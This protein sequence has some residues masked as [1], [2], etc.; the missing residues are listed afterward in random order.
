MES[1]SNYQTTARTESY[2]PLEKSHS[3]VRFKPICTGIFNKIFTIGALIFWGIYMTYYQTTFQL[4]IGL[5]F[6]LEN[7]IFL[8]MND[9]QQISFLKLRSILVYIWSAVVFSVGMFHTVTCIKMMQNAT[10]YG[11]DMGYS[12]IKFHEGPLLQLQLFIY[13]LT[14]IQLQA[15]TF[16]I[17]V[18]KIVDYYKEELAYQN[19][20]LSR[21][22]QIVYGQ[23][24]PQTQN[25][26]TAEG[27]TYGEDPKQA[28]N[29]QP[30]TYEYYDP[31]SQNQKANQVY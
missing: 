21:M 29:Q 14:F 12:N 23:K 31:N 16:V 13:L 27:I 8:M 1:K 11:E 4:A 15:L 25:Q 18:Y 26:N 6:P 3:S 28:S 9:K 2:L 30:L 24:A 22:S 17:Y 5:F 20:Y 19:Y 7:L 10:N